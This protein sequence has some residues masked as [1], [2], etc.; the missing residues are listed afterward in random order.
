MTTADELQFIDEILDEI[1]DK[2]LSQSLANAVFISEEIVCEIVDGA[3][4][5]MDDTTKTEVPSEIDQAEICN[6]TAA[7]VTPIEDSQWTTPETEAVYVALWDKQ[8]LIAE[9]EAEYNAKSK[10][11]HFEK[12][13]KT[14]EQ[15]ID[16]CLKEYS[17][18]YEAAHTVRLKFELEKDKFIAFVQKMLASSAQNRGGGKTC[19]LYYQNQE[20]TTFI[21]DFGS[22][23]WMMLYEGMDFQNLEYDKENV[24]KLEDINIGQ[25]NIQSMQLPSSLG[26]R[27][28]FVTP[29]RENSA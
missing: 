10:L 7:R 28:R 1:V 29:S 26:K 22:G 8:K 6:K 11:R 9:R 5:E 25:S 16:A 27:K 24:S 4:I 3:V 12:E 15:V 13:G 21:T 18:M 19:L 23:D 17:D 14:L 20:L 2:I